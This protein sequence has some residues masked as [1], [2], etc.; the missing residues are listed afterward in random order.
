MNALN[1]RIRTTKPLAPGPSHRKRLKSVYYFS[2][3]RNLT[4]P[5]FHFAL[6][7]GL[8]KAATALSVLLT[9]VRNLLLHWLG[10]DMLS[11]STKLEWSYSPCSLCL[12]SSLVDPVCMSRPSQ[13]SSR[14]LIFVGGKEREVPNVQRRWVFVFLL[15]LWSYNI[16]LWVMYICTSSQGFHEYMMINRP[17]KPPLRRKLA[18][19]S[20][21]FSFIHEFMT[22]RLPARLSVTVDPSVRQ[23]R[24]RWAMHQRSLRG[25]A[26]FDLTDIPTYSD[27]LGTR[28]KCHSNQFVTVSRGNLVTNESFGSC[29]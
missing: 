7:Q 12:Y 3:L 6:R 29:Q 1:A 25:L 4:L 15:S 28:P 27:T 5:L 8:R 2:L 18:Q 20:I 16:R 14:F 10:W 21:Q 9:K 13:W 24:W 23:R 11:G 19:I 22:F 26:D 17:S